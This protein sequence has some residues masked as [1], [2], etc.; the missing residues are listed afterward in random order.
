ML[1]IFPLGVQLSSVI[2]NFWLDYLM[3][4]VLVFGFL[5]VVVDWIV[6]GKMLDVELPRDLNDPTDLI[7]FD[8]AKAVIFKALNVKVFLVTWKE[9]VLI[10]DPGLSH[11]VLGNLLISWQVSSSL[12]E[13]ESTISP[14]F[15]CFLNSSLLLLLFSWRRRRPIIDRAGQGRVLLLALGSRYRGKLLQHGLR[16]LLE[17]IG[18]KG[19]L[20]SSSLDTAGFRAKDWLV[21]CGSL[22]PSWGRNRWEKAGYALDFD[23]AGRG[24]AAQ[25]DHECRSVD[26]HL[27]QAT[28]DKQ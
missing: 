26:C 2:V 13:S 16:S 7:R 25:F 18:A 12:E 14:S 15:S 8:H 20:T 24:R 10:V 17:N 22:D 1:S 6:T 9:V 19:A 21:Q 11:I 28:I 3:L 23:E 5:F 27:A 4:E